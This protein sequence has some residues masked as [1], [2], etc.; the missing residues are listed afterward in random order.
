MPRAFA[1]GIALL[2][3]AIA[4]ACGGRGASIEPAP[5]TVPPPPPAT[6]PLRVHVVYPPTEGGSAGSGE[7]IE[8]RTIPSYLMPRT[9]SA[10]IF[11]STGNA[12]AEL[13]VNGEPVPVYPSGGWIAWLP[14]IPMADSLAAFDVLAVR[15]HEAARVR[16][17]APLAPR[18]VPPATTAWIDTTSFRPTGRG[19]IRPG[20]G[21]TLS[22]R[23][24]P[25]ARVFARLLD[26]SVIT[27]VEELSPEA[28]PWGERAFG[29]EAP[30]L[31]PPV[32]GR[33]VAQW[34]GPIPPHPGDVLGTP[35]PPDT[36]LP[37]GAVVEAIVGSDT[38]RVTW[39][40][41]VAVLDPAHPTV[42]VVDDD[43]AG[44]GSDSVLAG[45]PAPNATYHWFFPAGTRAVVDGRWNDQARLRLSRTTAAWVDAADVQPLPP[46]TPPPSGVA[47]S[48]RLTPGEASVVLRVPLPARV[49]FRVDESEHVLRL[50]L[51][52]VAADMNWIQYGGTDAFVEL[53]EF[54]Q[55][56]EDEVVITTTL[57][58]PVWGYRTAWRG[59]DLLLEIRRP[60]PIDP[61]H[62]LVGR[63]I[64]VDAGHPPGGAT[65]PTGVR[66]ADVALAVA[67]EAA[68]LLEERGA[69]VVLTRTA[70]SAVGLADRPRLAE[71][72]GAELLVSIHANAL[73]DGMNPFVNS[74]T[75]VYFFH[76]R[77]AALA[78]AIDRALVRE[79]GARDLGVGRGDLA[80]A[81]PTWMPAVLIEGL[82]LMLPDHET[83]LASGE[84]QQRYARGIVE[85]LTVFLQGWGGEAPP[86]R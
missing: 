2:A 16:V 77:A 7:A 72:A 54:A 33:Y 21:V 3:A 29:T 1:A 62:P 11:G 52:G 66:E 38:A 26:G 82:F 49:P 8:V 75:S 24:V 50:T 23:A 80:L 78:R 41:R 9:D 37:A 10:F 39:P 17:V 53:V 12:A 70:D 61:A 63:V 28:V 13:W 57:A 20:E 25:G 14:V 32:P 31:G 67:L 60:P 86:G 76:P 43:T 15:G 46:G 6:G 68:R 27:F 34:D 45:R 19:W 69:S 18:Y 81:R 65:G 79:F 56:A 47:G 73:P 5:E 44:V 84:G 40:L 42:A 71:A 74:G 55:P 85:G 59:N 4:M 22:V 36:A 58:Q 35:A 30:R 64:A 48:M 83:V 51:Y